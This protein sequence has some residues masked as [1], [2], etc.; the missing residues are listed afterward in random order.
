VPEAWQT[1]PLSECA[2]IQTGIAK[3]RKLNGTQA[4]SVPYLRVANVQDGYLDLS[5]IKAIMIR[6]AEFKRFALEY[7]DVLLTEGGDFDKLGRGFIWRSQVPGCVHQN[8]IFA[9]RVKRNLLVPEFLAYLIQSPYGKAYFLSVAHKTTNLASINCTKLGRFP[10][11][12]PTIEEQRLIVGV[13]EACDTKMAALKGEIGLLDE[14][15]RAFLEE[16]MTGRLSAVPLI[17]EAPTS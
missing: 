14:L 8:H 2:Y 5:E 15:F 10:A 16:L 3:G 4:I 17:E 11:L 6:P 1:M 13:V 7:G 9:V 12:L